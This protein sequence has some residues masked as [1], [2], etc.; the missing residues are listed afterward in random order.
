MILV[1]KMMANKEIPEITSTQDLMDYL[2]NWLVQV[3][4]TIHNAKVNSIQAIKDGNFQAAAAILESCI[5]L[6]HEYKIA[7]FIKS[8]TKVGLIHTV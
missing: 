6:G 7:S 3:N 1:G 4:N 2:D 5:W 8:I